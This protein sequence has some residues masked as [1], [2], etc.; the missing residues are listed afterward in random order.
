MEEELINK[1]IDTL[2]QL[3]DYFEMFEVEGLEKINIC[4]KTKELIFWLQYYKELLEE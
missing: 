1:T 2:S 3:D 4:T